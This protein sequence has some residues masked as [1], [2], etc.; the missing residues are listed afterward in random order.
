MEQGDSLA[1]L[2]QQL[3]AY[4]DLNAI[5]LISHGGEGS[6]YLGNEQLTSA[7]LDQHATFLHSIRDALAD[8][9]DLL[10]Y[11]CDV[12]SGDR[13][14]TFL[15]DLSQRTRADIAASDDTT[16]NGGDWLLEQHTGR[17]DTGV[18]ISDGAQQAYQFS[19]ATFDMTA[20]SGPT[21]QYNQTVDTVT[22]TVSSPGDL[23]SS[24]IG[25]GAGS[26]GQTLITQGSG[27]N[28]TVTFDAPISISSLA[29]GNFN[30][31][32]QR[33]VI[34]PNSGSAVTS[35]TLAN[36]T[37]E[38]VTVNF[39]NITSFTVAFESGAAYQGILDTIVFTASANPAPD[40]SGTSSNQ[41]VN[42]NSTV[43]PFSGVT[44]SDNDNVSVTVT[45]DDHNKG[46]FTTG[47][48]SASGF[49]DNGGGTYSLA[50]TSAVNAQ[51]AI[52]QLVF[53]PTDN[54]QAP[55][56]TETTTFTLAVNDGF[57]DTV[58]TT[59][60][61]VSTSVNDSPSDISLSNSAIA[62]SDG[63]SN[64]TVGTLS[65]ID[66]DTGESFS[67]SLVSGSG[68]TDNSRF[69]IDGNVL[70]AKDPTAMADGNYS[71]RIQTDDGEAQFSEA[72]TI[73][74]TDDTPAEVTAI[75]LAS[76][77][78]LNADTVTFNVS[79][80]EVVNNLSADDF[81]LTTV[82]GNATG[83]ISS[84]S[85]S[86]G[87]SIN[88]TVN[89]IAGD[90][91]FRLDLKS[92]SDITDSRGNGN[93]NNGYTPDYQAGDLH[94]ADRV[95]PDV[96]GVTSTS[97]DG[98]YGVGDTITLTVNFSEAVAVTGAPELLLETGTTDRTATYSSG[99][100]TDTL[101]FTY[102]VQAG[103]R[104]ADLD[105]VSTTALNLA[106]GTIKDLAGNDASLT[107]PTPGSTGSLGANAELV[108]DTAGPEIL[109]VAIADVAMKVGDVVE[110]TITV[111]DDQGDHYSGLSG[112]IGGFNLSNLNRVDNTTYTA[113]FT[114]VES[115]TDVAAT[116]DLPVSLTLADTLGN[117]SATFD[118]P[119][120]QANDALDANS[121]AASAPQLE[122][123]SDSG[124]SNTDNVTNLAT[125]TVGASGAETG[126]TVSVRVAGLEVGTTVVDGTGHWQYQF[127][128]GDL[129]EGDNTIN[130]VLL[131]AAGNTSTV[132][133]DLTITLDTIAPTAADDT[134]A[135]VSEDAGMVAL[136]GVS[137]GHDNLLGNDTDAVAITAVNGMTTNL[138]S[139]T[140]GNNGGLFTILADGSASFDTSNE[141]DHLASGE[142]RTT[143]VTV[144]TLDTAGNT[145][146]ATLL[147]T[148][149]G[150]NDGP[151]LATN[152]GVSV[153]ARR[154]IT[155]TD[156]QLNEGDPDDDGTE[157]IYTLNTLPSSG[158]LRLEN[159]TLAA[160]DQFSQQD[161]ND[162]KVSF[163]A[164][165][166][167]GNVELDLT[168]SDGGEDGTTGSVET[169]SIT[170]TSPPPPPAP[171]P[172]PDPGPVPEP[173]P[174]PDTDGDG[175][176]QDEEAGAP[177]LNGDGVGDGNG[178]GIADT[179]QGNVASLIFL[180]SDRAESDP[181]GVPE[182]YLTL[183]AV[184][185]ESALKDLVQLNTPED[186]PDD[187]EMPLGLLSFG[188][189]LE[190]GSDSA[191]FELY[192]NSDLNINGYWKQDSNGDWVNL[193]SEAYGGSVS[194]VNDRLLLTFTIEDGGQFDDDG[195]VNGVITD[196]GAPGFRA[197]EPEPEPEPPTPPGAFDGLPVDTFFDWFEMG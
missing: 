34:T 94:T 62:H 28:L 78:D 98:G 7:T 5:H 134:G 80:S 82:T 111:T 118:T 86:S 160:G 106:G 144:T 175:I 9:G 43:T 115:G 105:Y 24:G 119:I 63:Q 96:V 133:A 123:T 126:A 109:T 140:A 23:I 189:E 55:G 125:A 102:M 2:A 101:S 171:D 174:D 42:D 33:V 173:Q 64:V 182:I 22:M 56:A 48:L 21:K 81:V 136:T 74:V 27:G 58:D 168:I 194:Q 45:L 11:G 179:E 107:L 72:H 77:P 185:A 13:G 122:A 83:T 26:T 117:R 170:V 130:T 196:P 95:A 183:A 137:S 17:I 25:D 4:Q 141:F 120:S 135:T 71:V 99:S 180:E 15:R 176:P 88:V 131:D 143:E 146:D 30:T 41:A 157:V 151:S 154:S 85:T 187:L 159:T 121:P 153:Q 16:G 181:D 158:N 32:N 36:Q 161:I 149:E 35:N 169:V 6:L 147:V 20:P 92:N 87:N 84:A 49:S 67:Y 162:G 73:Q 46:V 44:I 163:L 60:S 53:D 166:R 61:V 40:I 69:F 18:A 124:V 103:D 195:Q 31:N 184:S 57:R 127:G 12:A 116:D 190:Q 138:A 76:S 75:S 197:P 172:T 1:F 52:R 110:A 188:A 193:A 156:A 164:G 191:T 50:S 51:A 132:S 177:S 165:N 142:T 148:V 113:Q 8:D 90:G 19:L 39:T 104:S 186:R 150:I 112:T 192:L 29:V 37:G 91:S 47:S 54:R 65:S 152:T 66:P 70:K 145:S 108:V 129:T 155:F 38:T 93:G 79:F 114:V 68:D 59:A 139:A 14:L 167:R 3:N 97:P 89:S 10:L 178:D 100:G 128:A